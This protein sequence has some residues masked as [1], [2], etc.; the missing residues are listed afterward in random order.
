MTRQEIIIGLLKKASDCYYNTENFYEATEEEVNTVIDELQIPCQAVMSDTMF[1]EIYKKAK[2]KYPNDVYF[3]SV[4][5]EVRGDKVPLPVPMGS[6]VE[7]KSTE[8]EPWLVKGTKYFVSSKLDGNS[9]LLVYENGNL[10]IAYTRGDGYEGQDIT[11]HIKNFAITIPQNVM[12]NGK[13]FT[14]MVRGEIIVPKYD[15]QKMIDELKVETGKEYKNGRNTV[16]GQLNSKVCA[17][18][19]LKYAHFVAYYIDGQD[20]LTETEKFLKI[21]QLG[22]LIPNYSI[23]IN[24]SENP[25]KEEFF[26][27]YVKSV[28][29]NDRY[30]C[31]GII[32]TQDKVLPGYEGFE[33]STL[34]PKCSRKFKVG[35][36]NN[37]DITEVE[38]IQWNVS[39]DGYF[40]PRVKV[41]PVNIQGVTIEWATGHNYKNV[42]DMKICK[43]AKIQIK[44]S[45]DVIPYIEKVLEYPEEQDYTLPDKDL[46]AYVVNN[47]NSIVDIELSDANVNEPNNSL[48]DD[49][50]AYFTEMCL[51]KLVY[52]CQKMKVDFAGEGNIKKLMQETN[53]FN[54]DVKNLLMIPMNVFEKAIGVNGIKF[55][56][57]LQQTL[58][59]CTQCQFYDATGTFGRGIGEL[60]LQKVVDMYGGLPFDEVKMMVVD[61][62]ALNTID[63]Y[64]SKYV[65]A[66]DWVDWLLDNKNFSFKSEAKAVGNKYENVKVV[67]TGVRDKKLE[68][69]I[70]SNGG[71]VLSSC[72][73]ECNLVVAKDPSGSSSKLDKARKQGVEIISLQEA[74][75][76]FPDELPEKKE[77]QPIDNPLLKALQ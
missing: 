14:G 28:K 53:N 15:I 61:G 73:K 22:F 35:A 39:K 71:K 29:E 52:Y 56:D 69:I 20:N 77:E 36:T 42:V 40:K 70:K 59:N 7:C 41:K 76:R 64:M 66:I 5:S 63:Q 34:N 43:G 58:K 48:Y 18:A 3:L 67:F 37:T 65:H 16:A 12:D 21:R 75:E 13:P 19:F 50:Q 51:Q 24:S 11:R 47:D 31:D 44:R 68:L 23:V 33:T 26:V 32:I 1:D 57:S 55:Y 46:F 8:L 4:G 27:N 60:K 6:M 2:D 17:K 72:T 45:G 10:K 30:E 38:Y 49:Y 62:W 25:L 9:A 54:M 74:L